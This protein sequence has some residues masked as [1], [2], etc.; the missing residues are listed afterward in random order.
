MPKV[1]VIIPCYN[2]QKYI[3]QCI[4]SLLCQ[5]LSDFEIIC[6]DDGSTDETPVILKEYAKND[7][8][9]KVLEQKNL[10]AGVARNKGLAVAEGEYVIFLDGDDFFAENMLETVCRAADEKGADAVIFGFRRFDD[11]KQIFFP[12]EE[13]PRTDLIPDTDVFSAKDIPDDIFRVTSPAP[14][15]KLFRRS[16]IDKTGLEFQ[17]L[18]NSND[19]FFILSAISMAERICAVSEALTFY[20][21]NMATSI[22]GSKHKN[23]LCFLEAIDALYAQLNKTGL[24]SLLEKAFTTVALSSTHYNLRSA[25]TDKARFTVLEALGSS[26]NSVNGL[27]GHEEEYYSNAASFKHATTINCAVEQ[28]RNVKNTKQK[29]DTLPVIPYRSDKKPKVSVI[30]PVYNTGDY[31]HATLDSICGQTLQ[32]IEIICINDG[33]TD[34]SLDILKGWA[35]KDDRIS[36][37]TQENAGLSCTRNSGVRI[38]QG[39]YVYFMDSD[40]ILEGDTLELLF[41]KA[42]AENLDVVY[43][44]ADVFCEEEDFEEHI[45]KYNYKRSREYS[46]VYQGQELFKTLYNNGEY[47]PSAC[48]QMLRKGF[49]EEL[50]LSFHPGIIHEDNAFTFTA[51]LNAERVSHINRPFFHRRLRGNSI[52]TT[53][54]SFKN[55][56]G[57]FVSYQ[58]MLRAYIRVE[59]KLTEENRE[60]ALTRIGQNLLNAQ[61]SYANMPK[62]Q[63]G[64]ELG[65][66]GDRR[67]FERMVVRAGNAYRQCE[68]LKN[69]NAKN[70][71]DRKEL[72]AKNKRVTKNYEKLK[73]NHKKLNKRYKKLKKRDKRIRRTRLQ[74]FIICCWDHSFSYAVKLSF[75]RLFGKLSGKK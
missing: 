5:T 47:F 45:S 71:Q 49:I 9:I 74:R 37:W 35:E 14:W 50:G 2:A 19:F 72:I 39:K 6:V 64:A 52:M 32:E 16:F 70:Q 60:A 7:K 30:I 26:D 73:V 43:F 69:K 63:L 36:L 62:E 23:P 33:S 58:D 51:I 12:K 10:Y 21:V 3:N 27:L 46:E 25:S 11:K 8:R 29:A 61:N 75:K 42:D 59:D 1:S 57:Y 15:T 24:Y 55:A 44:D 13:L 56:Y 22:Q 4:D 66:I 68:E 20:R 54:V 38:A 17:P 31:L 40:D 53:T 18:P 28:F 41:E 65:L 67:S 34:N 48:L